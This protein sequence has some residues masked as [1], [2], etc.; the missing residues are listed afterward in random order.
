MELEKQAVSI[1][2]TPITSIEGLAKRTLVL[3]RCESKH[4]WLA[5]IS[6]RQDL[7]T[8]CPYCSGRIAIRGEN[9]LTTSHPSLA[10]EF[11]LDKNAPLRPDQIKAGS[12]KAFW[13]LCSNGHSWEAIAAN[14]SRR[15]DG[16]PYCSGRDAIEG[17]SDIATIAPYLY[18]QLDKSK[19]AIPL[20]SLKVNSNSKVWWLCD[21]GHSYQASPNNRHS[22]NSGC[23]FCAGK[24]VFPGFNDL[25][26]RYP[27]VA[28]SW[29]PRNLPLE[30]EEVTSGSNRKVWWL[31]PVGHEWFSS[32]KNR[33]KSGCPVCSGKR[34]W[35]GFNDLPTT[36]PELLAEWDYEKNVD[37]DP[38]AVGKAS[39]VSVWWSCHQGHNWKTK[40]SIRVRGSGCPTCNVGGYNPSAPSILYFLEHKEFP[41][42]KLGIMN[43]GTKR[44]ENLERYGWQVRHLFENESGAK[45]RSLESALFAWVRLELGLNPFFSRS[46]MKRTAG[47]TET[48]SSNGI[49]L[50]EV[51]RKIDIEWVRLNSNDP[52]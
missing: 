14:R 52:R 17:E 15:G 43:A 47:Y 8:G 4:E 19:N 9:D 45:I 26:C 13:W 24:A 10:L 3:W 16:C 42:Y 44:L 23:P 25:K 37:L 22:R 18:A 2:G 7:G 48:F 46:D 33:L 38:T 39:S 35:A 11:D 6:S 41:A 36:N 32:V 31:C 5:T 49:S 50:K 1:N 28:M 27:S 21:L 29:S 34:I 20:S 30:P 40:T 12:G 51:I